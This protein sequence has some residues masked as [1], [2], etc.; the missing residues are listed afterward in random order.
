MILSGCNNVNDDLH[1]TAFGTG[2][3]LLET[4][5]LRHTYRDFAESK[6]LPLVKDI[7]ASRIHLEA[8]SE[9]AKTGWHGLTIP[10]EYDGSDIGYL[11]DSCLLRR[12]HVFHQQLERCCN[13]CSWVWPW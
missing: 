4:A 9:I 6:I 8:V 2:S 5:H 13:Q 12:F 11:H 7:E 3:M 1:S 10:R